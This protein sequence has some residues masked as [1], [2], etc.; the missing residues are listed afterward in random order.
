MTALTI[1]ASDS[2]TM[3]RR[4]LKR[5]LRYPSLTVFIVGT[6]VVFLLLFTY[7][8]GGMLGAGIG[9]VTGGRADYLR[10]VTPGILIHD[11]G[12]GGPGNVPC[13]GSPSIGRSRRQPRPS[14]VF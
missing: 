11:R 6:P 10:Y 4:N 5:M 7:V 13:A 12:D 9:G 1:A 8:F 3:L 14:V 2:A